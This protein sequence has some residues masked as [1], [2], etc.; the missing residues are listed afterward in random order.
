MV[1]G[2]ARPG[3]PQRR[4]G[5][6]ANRSLVAYVSYLAIQRIGC[7]VVPISL[8]APQ[9]RLR[10]LC[11]E[12]SLDGIVADEHGACRIAGTQL[13]ADI[14]VLD[15][16]DMAAEEL[17]AGGA[18]G[19]AEILATET[20]LAYILFTSGSTG[21][22]KGVPI[23][24][25]NIVP[26]IT[27]NCARYQVGPNSRLSQTF[28]LT[29]DPSVFDLFVA[30]ASGA[31]LVVPDRSELLSPVDFVK[32]TR[33]THWFSV[34][35]LISMAQRQ[36]ELPADSMPDLEWSLFAGEQLTIDQARAWR[37]A[38][39]RAV[40]ENLYGP[41]EL[42]VTCVA[43]RLPDEPDDWPRTSNGTVP[44]GAVYGHMEGMIYEESDG[45][46]E[47]LIRGP[48]RFDGYLNKADNVGRFVL[49]DGTGGF[50]VLGMETPCARH[51]YRTGDLVERFEDVLVHKGR[52][53]D[54]LKVRGVRV[55]ASEIEAAVRRH[56]KVLEAAVVSVKTTDGDAELVAAYTGEEVS[57][58]ELLDV[59][60]DVI[61]WHMVPD[62]FVFMPRLPLNANGK[63]D[64]SSLHGQFA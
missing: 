38:A 55:E 19:E 52:V 27:Y 41:T 51:W 14:P 13:A 4:F 30:W 33:I 39:P 56:E 60:R 61:P 53:D 42:S 18:A 23:Y 44:I 40:V 45:Q 3:I 9:E 54:Q 1:D 6:L 24:H 43:H 29:F 37:A 10:V 48:Q 28:D 12:A 22:P 7:A 17:A 8:D 50:T 36:D 21:R 46:G 5:L 15:L 35:S 64:R 63:I 59:L 57:R 49:D 2:L 32:R 62:R 31:A 11:E 25:S 34:P 47:L 58:R 26:Y 20:G 16:S